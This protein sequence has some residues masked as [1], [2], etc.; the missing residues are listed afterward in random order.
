MRRVLAIAGGAAIVAFAL[1]AYFGRDQV[2][3]TAHEFYAVSLRSSLFSGFL[4][5]GGFLLSLKTFIVVK[6]KEGLYDHPGY[7]R[8]F[9]E[10]VAVRSATPA[11]SKGLYEPLGQLRALLFLSIVS[12]L[13][14]AV[15]QLTIGLLDGVYVVAIAAASVAFTLALLAQALVEINANLKA[16]FKHLEEQPL[17]VESADTAAAAAAVAGK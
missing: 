5:L 6:M 7:R 4:G 9:A 17:A 16:W 8:R 13:L 12:S 11:T 1:V 14:T 3:P 2:K 10:S 15:L